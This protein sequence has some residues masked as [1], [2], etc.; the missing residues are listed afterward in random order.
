MSTAGAG[1]ENADFAAD[2]GK[3]AKQIFGPVQIAQD[4]LVGHPAA[5]ANFGADIFGGA[6]AVAE[7]EIGRDGHVTV[8]GKSTG[9]FAIP[10]IPAGGMMNGYHGG[11]RTGAQ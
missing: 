5:G 2:V 10:F 4:L 1:S 8:V 6:M 11:K 9:A 3:R 7:I